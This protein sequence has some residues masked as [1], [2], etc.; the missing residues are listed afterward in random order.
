MCL[1]KKD[2]SPLE[3]PTLPTSFDELWNKVKDFAQS[4]PAAETVASEEKVKP[5]K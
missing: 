1:V 2:D 3:L 5:P 4:S